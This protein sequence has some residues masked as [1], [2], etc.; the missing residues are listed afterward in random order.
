MCKITLTFQ[1]QLAWPWLQRSLFLLHGQ[2]C[3]CYLCLKWNTQCKRNSS[4]KHFNSVIMFSSSC[5]SKSIWSFM[6]QHINFVVKSVLVVLAHA[7][8]YIW[9]LKL[10]THT[11]VCIYILSA[12]TYPIPNIYDLFFM[13]LQHFKYYSLMRLSI[14]KKNIIINNSQFD[15]HYAIKY[16]CEE[17]NE[18]SS[19]INCICIKKQWPVFW[20]SPFAT[21]RQITAFAFRLPLV[22]PTDLSFL[23][24]CVIKLAESNWVRLLVWRSCFAQS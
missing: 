5:Y 11:H 9:C 16:L 23:L 2:D 6:E 22:I 3:I 12:Y 20:F 17:H 18:M 7:F 1:E 13:E 15:M 8:I 14:F 21:H 24:L 4:P 10:E 19:H